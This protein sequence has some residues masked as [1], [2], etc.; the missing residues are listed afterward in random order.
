[1]L[2]KNILLTEDIGQSI[3]NDAIMNHQIVKIYY[4]GDENTHKGERI[5]EPYVL[6]RT[7]KMKKAIRAFQ[8]YGDTQ[9]TVPNWK[10][11]ILKNIKSWI[12][13]NKT[14]NSP[15]EYRNF[16]VEPY[17][18]NGD[19]SLLNIIS[20]ATFNSIPNTSNNKQLQ[21]TNANDN[22]NFQSP[23]EKVK[24]KFQNQRKQMYKIP[25]DLQKKRFNTS[26]GKTTTK[27]QEDI[28][29]VGPLTN[30]DS[31]TNDSTMQSLLKNNYQK[32]LE[33]NDYSKLDV[34]QQQLLKNLQDYQKRKNNFRQK[35]KA[36][37]L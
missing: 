4:D 14:F 24:S 15:P 37:E 32:G 33:N 36:N 13:T 9:T 5:I 2:K 10:I 7:S 28:P 18:V 11:F 6:G 8:P 20:Q 23:L 12:P 35:N 19:S 29:S 3:V 30:D 21:Q 31:I 25:T 17:N 26:Q 16:N 1:M 27:Q 34:T 22:E